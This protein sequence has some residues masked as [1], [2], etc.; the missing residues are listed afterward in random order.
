MKKRLNT[1]LR[2]FTAL[3]ACLLALGIAPLPAQPAGSIKVSAQIR[4]QSLAD[5][6]AQWEE[7][8][9]LRF[10]YPPGSLPARPLEAAFNEAPLPAALDELLAGS[11][12]G[13]FFYRDYAVAIAPHHIIEGAYSADYYRALA[14]SLPGGGAEPARREADILVIGDIRG[15]NPSGRA[16]I[17]GIV[18]DEQSGEPIIGAAI[19]CAGQGAASEADGR[20]TLTLPTGSHELQVQHV[21]YAPLLRMVKVYG[22]GELPLKLQPSATDLAEVLVRAQATDANVSNTR[23]GVTRLEVKSIERLPTLLGEA[24]VLRSLL[25][26]SG[27]S[28]VGEGAAGFNV[29]GGETGQNLLL[30]D[31][32]VLFNATHA[33]GFF[34]TFNTDLTARVE[35]YKSIIPARYGGRLASVL[36]V[37][38]REGSFEKWKFRGGAGPVSGRLSLEGPVIKGKSSLIAGL[39][40]SYSDWVLRLASRPEVRRSSAGF[41]D[42]NFRYT[43]RLDGKN[44][45][46]LAGYAAGDEFVYNRAF[47]FDYRTRSGQLIYKRIFHD[48]FFSRLSLAASSYTSAQTNREGAQS[49]QL[50]NG[51]TYYKLKEALTYTFGRSLQLDAGLEG[52]YY[53]VQ[54]GEQRP[55]G[56][57]SVIAP[58]SLEA[59]QALE[60]A[61]FG[62]VEWTASARLALIAGLRFN[63]YRFLGPKTVF[64]YDGPIALEN[65]EE[66]VRYGKGQAIVTYNNLEPRLSAR[67]RLGST[68]SIKAG[69]SRTS[70]FI[71]QIFNTDT[72]TPTS[73]YQLST[74]Y[75]RPFRA[76]NFAAGYFRNSPDNE[77]E[78]SAEVFYRNIDQMWDYRDFARLLVNESLETE[79]L[80]GKGR[81]YGL[82][83]NL[84][85]TRQMVNGQL[86]Y[87]WSRSERQAPGIN[88]GAWYPSNFDKP[89]NFNLVVNYQ[90]SQRHNLAFNFTYSTGRPATA[91]LTNHR[92]SNGI[93]VPVYTLRN[94]LRIPDYH[95]LD[96]SY[97]IGRG[98]NKHKTLKA[99]W[100]ISIYN[101]YARKNAFSVFFTPSPSLETVANRLAILGSAFPAI[102]INL[103]TI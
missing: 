56:A 39:R 61:A 55:L 42:A 93:I 70:Q 59:E 28:S 21:G 19:L 67:Y 24:D 34:S 79:I 53:R 33:L 92:L 16:G 95:R 2:S 84:K 48:N 87:T 40:A 54:P 69:Y 72:P 30:Q 81:A 3:C 18:T 85:T 4:Q 82:E 10:Y 26:S 44:T 101:V 57:A 99:S 27:V 51:I 17:R 15:L 91:P 8:Y 74:E 50:D 94:Q 25:L 77:W 58:K 20:F 62:S 41:Y 65:R 97:T 96:V 37:E 89:H 52:V 38:M 46:T 9:R 68:A 12:L 22:D 13:Y 73:Q 6:L 60:S 83:L 71:N 47:G 45:L 35:L 103:A 49:G 64:R 5:I 75:I 32:A 11:G 31:E 100:N 88:R 76:H 102:T 23:I 78:G 7:Q 14:Q 80:N 1:A 66:A 63:H 86:S 98:Y 43:H 90:P 29:R 36:D